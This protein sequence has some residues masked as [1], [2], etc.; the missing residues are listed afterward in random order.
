[1]HIFLFRVKNPSNFDQYRVAL[2]TKLDFFGIKY[3][4]NLLI[5]IYT[6]IQEIKF[7]QYLID[8][9]GWREDN[10][11]KHSTPRLDSQT[12]YDRKLPRLCSQ[13]LYRESGLALKSNSRT[14]FH[15][16]V[17]LLLSWLSEFITA[18][19]I[20]SSNFTPALKSDS[21]WNLIK[22]KIYLQYFSS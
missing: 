2:T 3:N 17:N 4:F 9:G 7:Y 18:F 11:I 6:L 14:Q 16:C 19:K 20:Y 21:D 12:K 22:I 5:L 1:M 13:K 15:K 8:R 10:F